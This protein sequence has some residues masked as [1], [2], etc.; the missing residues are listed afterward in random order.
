[1]ERGR[2]REAFRIFVR[3]P[4]A[5]KMLVRL[6]AELVSDDPLTK[7]DRELQGP[8]DTAFK[9]TTF[10][11]RWLE[12]QRTTVSSILR[13]FSP[14]GPPPS[15]R[16][17]P[18][19]DNTEQVKKHDKVRATGNFVLPSAVQPSSPRAFLKFVGALQ[20][21]PSAIVNV[22]RL[23]E[24]IGVTEGDRA[25]LQRILT[26]A[27]NRSRASETT[28]ATAVFEGPSF[29]D[30]VRE[31]FMPERDEFKDRF[32]AGLK[33]V[34][35]KQYGLK[36][37]GPGVDGV[38]IGLKDVLGEMRLSQNRTGYAS[39]P[40]FTPGVE[41]PEPVLVPTTACLRCH[42][43]RPSGQGRGTDP[44]PP[45]AFDP[46]DK[47]GREAWLRTAALAEKQRVLGRM[48]RRLGEEKDMPPEDAPEFE[49]FRVKEA[50]AFEAVRLFLEAEFKKV[51][52]D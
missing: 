16:D 50:A 17:K 31:G 32:L 3:Y 14:V 10:S 21:R 48:L 43:I 19:G 49:Q 6:L 9:E 46:F 12:Y 8:I 5:P 51:K 23:A 41:E 26:D 42:D 28:L 13:D 27:S 38:L 25:F 24:T 7:T 20:G 52:K 15:K 36:S 37:E 45:L 35:D 2:N 30:V 4:G 18:W 11:Q 29:A 22:T 44:L 33:E 47:K 1:V 34:L 40:E 39:T